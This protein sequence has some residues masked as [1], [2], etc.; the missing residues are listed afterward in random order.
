MIKPYQMIFTFSSKNHSYMVLLFYVQEQQLNLLLLQL[1]YVFNY[2]ENTEN[3]CIFKDA[4]DYYQ[5]P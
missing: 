2:F 1:R 5:T 4:F 3:H